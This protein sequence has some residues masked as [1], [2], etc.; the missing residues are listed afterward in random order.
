[1]SFIM[2]TCSF[3][4]LSCRGE[5]RLDMFSSVQWLGAATPYH[6]AKTR[7]ADNFSS[8]LPLAGSSGWM[9]R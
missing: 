1:M 7:T 2:Y 5:H 4:H 3:L 6:F 9:A 8:L